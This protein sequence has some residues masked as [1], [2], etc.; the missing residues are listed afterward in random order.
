MADPDAVWLDPGPASG[1]G[2]SVRVIGYSLS[3]HAVLSV[4]LLPAGADPG[5]RPRGEWWG[6][7]PGVPTPVTVA[8]MN[9]PSKEVPNEQ[10]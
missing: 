10:G 6:A 5:D 7:T 9:K 1:S 2:L 4:V 3:A 8:S